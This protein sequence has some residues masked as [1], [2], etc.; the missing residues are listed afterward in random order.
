MSTVGSCRIG[1]SLTCTKGD[2]WGRGGMSEHGDG[3]ERKLER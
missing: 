2:E 3:W 1:I